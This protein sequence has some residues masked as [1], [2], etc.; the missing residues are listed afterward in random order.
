M[1][2]K[3]MIDKIIELKKEK[4]AVILA[5]YYQDIEVQNIADYIGDSF[6]LAKR[7]KEAEEEVIVFCGVQ[8]MAE[9]AKILNPKKKVLLPVKEAGCPMADMVTSEDVIELKKKYPEATVVA[10]V[11]SSADVKTVTDICCTSSSVEKIVNAID[12]KQI[13]FIPDQNLGNYISTIVEDKEIITINGFCIVHHRME[14]EDVIKAKEK[15][16]NAAFA[17]HPECRKEV[18][19]EADYVGSTSGIIK[20]ALESDN[21]EIIIGTENGVIDFLKGKNNKKKYYPLS[22][23]MECQNMKKTSLQDVLNALENDYYEINLDANTIE[24]AFNSL[25]RMMK[26]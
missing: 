11:N 24:K 4:N 18:W 14:K 7:A 8:F 26:I 20:F 21:D 17:V 13:I 15:Y 2:N 3:E 1:K 10:Y 12:S 6:E 25:D 16:P 22:E 23:Y 19:E 9:G 5:H